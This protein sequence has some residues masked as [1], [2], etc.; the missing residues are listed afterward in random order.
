MIAE[1]R[2]PPLSE[3]ASVISNIAY[4]RE[5]EEAFSSDSAAAPVTNPKARLFPVT[6]SNREESGLV[7]RSFA[8]KPVTVT[9]NNAGQSS[10][11]LSV[12]DRKAPVT[13]TG[14]SNPSFPVTDTGV[15]DTGIL[16]RLADEYWWRRALR[17]VY[18]RKFEHGAIRLGLVH[19]REGKYVSDETLKRRQKQNRRNCHIFQHQIVT[20][21]LGQEYSRV[22]GRKLILN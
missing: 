20:N 6:V 14:K 2:Q 3:G 5:D 16:A 18:G 11:A 15:S 8:G 12:T 10:I 7:A 13:V 9:G 19:S 22:E 4:Y 21:E 17:K 1:S